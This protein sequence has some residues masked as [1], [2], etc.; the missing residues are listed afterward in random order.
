MRLLKRIALASALGALA[1]SGTAWSRGNLENPAPGS[2]L[3]GIG[4]FSGWHCSAGTV[5]IQIDDLEPKLAAYGTTRKDTLEVCGQEYTGFSL[6]W[7]F[8]ILGDGPHTVRALADG[9]EFDRAEFAVQ[10]LDGAFIRGL[11]G[12][13]R[14]TLPQLGLTAGLAWQ[15]SL[16]N[17]TIVD[18]QPLRTDIADAYQGNW[19]GSWLAEGFVQ[20][21]MYLVL[22]ASGLADDG[23]IVP[24]DLMLN[25]TGCA[26]SA[27]EL[28][29]ITSLDFPVTHATMTDLSEVDLRLM[30]APDNS[31]LAGTFEFTSGICSG[32]AGSFTLFR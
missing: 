29:N 26:T 10:T 4:V 32:F 22:D 23:V 17:F 31:F 12:E 2:T 24:T 15:Q 6:L 8:N 14:V 11:E 18:T 13:T 9:V 25:A 21:A 28:S 16:Q 1:L 27:F 7:N 20:G 30:P 19:S 3:G 5:E